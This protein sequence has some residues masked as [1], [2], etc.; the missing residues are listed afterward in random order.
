MVGRTAYCHQVD[1]GIPIK[2]T[3]VSLQLTFAAFNRLATS[4]A[5]NAQVFD[6]HMSCH[7]LTNNRASIMIQN[8]QGPFHKQ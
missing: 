8:A 3:L 1:G 4:G 6:M 7:L 2:A 5:A